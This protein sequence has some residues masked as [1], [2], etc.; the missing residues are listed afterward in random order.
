MSD[1]IKL[2]KKVKNDRGWAFIKDDELIKIYRKI[3]NWQI[4]KSLGYDQ[5]V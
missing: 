1:T 2:S 5:I 4:L 3:Q